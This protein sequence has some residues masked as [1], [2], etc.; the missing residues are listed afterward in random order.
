MHILRHYRQLNLRFGREDVD[1]QTRLPRNR[2]MGLAY[3]ILHR[4]LGCLI[5]QY[6]H[7]AMHTMPYELHHLLN[8]HSFLK[9]SAMWNMH[10]WVLVG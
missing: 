2:L 9:Q 10:S 8:D 5:R 3:S 7:S 6:D 1:L 4:L